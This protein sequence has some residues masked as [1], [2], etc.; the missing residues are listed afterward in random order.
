MKNFLAS[1]VPSSAYAIN[2]KNGTTDCVT[3]WQG[4][5]LVVWLWPNISL[6]KIYAHICYFLVKRWWLF[7]PWNRP[8]MCWITVGV[9]S[10]LN[11]VIVFLSPIMWHHEQNWHWNP[12][13]MLHFEL[14][15]ALAEFMFYLCYLWTWSVF[16][17]FWVTRE[18]KWCF[19]I[20]ISASSLESPVPLPLRTVSVPSLSGPRVKGMVIFAAGSQKL[21]LISELLFPSSWGHLQSDQSASLMGGCKTFLRENIMLCMCGVLSEKCDLL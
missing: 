9:L 12:L 10:P 8:A 15:Q 4:G 17:H 18:P 21:C 20:Q 13:N 5:A 3:V 19:E 2:R 1:A 11:D 7:S 6:Q 14:S 16:G